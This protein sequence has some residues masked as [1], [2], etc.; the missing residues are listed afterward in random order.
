MRRDFGDSIGS[1]GLPARVDAVVVRAIPE[2]ELGE[3]AL[4]IVH[5]DV[6]VGRYHQELFI[7]GPPQT[8]DGASVPQNAAQLL[9]GIAVDVDAGLGGRVGAVGLYLVLVP[10]ESLQ[11]SERRP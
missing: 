11:G 4:D 1:G 2:R 6:A 8:L 5:P 10:I 9:A 7:L 3:F